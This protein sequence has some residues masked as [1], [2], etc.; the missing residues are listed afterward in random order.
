MAAR[1]RNRRRVHHRRRRNPVIT[2]RVRNRRRVH[3]R[4]RNPS[5]FSGIS[6]DLTA[7]IVAA[8]GA[9]ATQTVQQMMGQFISTGT[10]MWVDIGVTVGAAVAVGFLA[11][12]LGFQKYSK[13]LVIGGM[14]LAGGKLI[15]WAF[16]QARGLTGGSTGVSGLGARRRRRGMSDVVAL[17]GG[18]WDSYYG[19]TPAGTIPGV[20]DVVTYAP[21]VSY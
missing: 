11:D 6:G 9:M 10:S 8:G 13:L 15:A 16:A 12:K 2:T 21:G 19:S 17:P 18:T 5:V 14:S 3:H 20:S 7:G 1:R 4:R